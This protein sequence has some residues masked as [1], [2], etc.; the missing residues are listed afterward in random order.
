MTI[1]RCVYIYIYIYIYTGVDP[2]HKTVAECCE[3][4]GKREN[5]V[6][7]SI[8]GFE[9]NFE[10]T[11]INNFEHNLAQLIRKLTSLSKSRN[12]VLEQLDRSKCRPGATGSK[13]CPGAAG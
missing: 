11:T 6:Y 5:E 7:I 3:R 12:V 10:Q 2:R 4:V 13:C 9:H 1:E 8:T